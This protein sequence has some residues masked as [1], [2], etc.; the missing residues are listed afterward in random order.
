MDW[1]IWKKNDDDFV[2]LDI[3]IKESGIEQAVSFIVYKTEMKWN[4]KR[5]NIFCEGYEKDYKNFK[6]DT[7]DILE[8]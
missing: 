7:K 2:K 1:D 8:T 6:W 5:K 4:I 3:D